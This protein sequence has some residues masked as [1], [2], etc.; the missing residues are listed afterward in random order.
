MAVVVGVLCVFGA[1]LFV[2]FGALVEMFQQLKQVRGYL[3]LV[4]TPT[5]IELG[6]WAGVIPSSIGLPPALDEVG[7]ALVVFLSNKCETCRIIAQSLAG[8][9]LPQNLWLV[10]V[11]VLSDPT[12]FLEEFQLRGDRTLIDQ[13]ITDR[14]GL[15]I[16]PAALLIQNGRIVEA[17]TLPSV[18]QL[19]ASLPGIGKRSRALVP[20]AA[21]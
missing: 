15:D 7:E 1:A 21:A 4:D 5:P 2:Q 19:Y 13:G 18:R 11:P 3:D 8:G 17:H 6:K 10:V 9:A 12:E 14:I 16:T 20:R